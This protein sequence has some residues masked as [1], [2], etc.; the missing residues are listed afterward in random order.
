MDFRFQSSEQWMMELISIH[1]KLN[2]IY[3]HLR[4]MKYTALNQSL[5]NDLSLHDESQMG[6]DLQPYHS[7]L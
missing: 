7:L 6:P 3:F 5:G 2:A 4:M 1:L